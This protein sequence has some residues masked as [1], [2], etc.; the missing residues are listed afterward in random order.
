MSRER[1]RFERLEV[2]AIERAEREDLRE[3][4]QEME[5]GIPG[6]VRNFS[7]A[8]LELWLEREAEVPPAGM[9]IDFPAIEGLGFEGCAVDA[10]PV[11][12]DFVDERFQRMGCELVDVD[13]Q[14][15]RPLKH[16]SESLEALAETP[17]RLCVQVTPAE[18]L[19]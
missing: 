10:L 5:T 6:L 8:G 13:E 16:L 4:L 2:F 1:R 3:W 12:R 14:A 17:W 19:A 7:W 18:G 15:M 11:W 9:H